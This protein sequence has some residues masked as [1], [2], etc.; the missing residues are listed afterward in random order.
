MEA[1]NFIVKLIIPVNQSRCTDSNE[2][3]NMCHPHWETRRS[4]LMNN[5]IC[6]LLYL[7]AYKDANVNNKT[8]ATV[9]LS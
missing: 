8:A 7:H 3:N 5:G 1:R 9:N 2:R 4:R 6:L